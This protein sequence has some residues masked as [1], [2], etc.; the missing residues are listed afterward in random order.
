MADMMKDLPKW[1]TPS[2]G[3]HGFAE[4]AEALLPLKG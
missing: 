4:L 3:S 1:V 2:A